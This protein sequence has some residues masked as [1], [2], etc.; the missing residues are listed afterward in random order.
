MGG[1]QGTHKHEDTLHRGLS[2]PGFQCVR[3]VPEPPD[4]ARAEAEGPSCAWGRA[5]VMSTQLLFAGLLLRCSLLLSLV[6]LGSSQAGSQ[7]Q[8]AL[9]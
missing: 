6:I 7:W 5:G 9:F 1:P 4:E 8:S 3:E 2:F